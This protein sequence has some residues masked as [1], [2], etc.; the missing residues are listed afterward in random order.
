MVWQAV[1]GVSANT[2]L[3]LRLLGFLAPKV[4]CWLSSFWHSLSVPSQA[5]RVTRDSSTREDRTDRLSR[6]VSRHHRRLDFLQR[7]A[8]YLRVKCPDFVMTSAGQESKIDAILLKI[9]NLWTKTAGTAK[10]KNLVLIL[11]D[12]FELLHTKKKTMSKSAAGPDA[13]SCTP[14]PAPLSVTKHRNNPAKRRLKFRNTSL[15]SVRPSY[16][17]TPETADS[18][19]PLGPPAI[20]HTPENTTAVRTS[21]PTTWNIILAGLPSAIRH[22]ER[23]IGRRSL[24]FKNV[25][26]KLGS[27]SNYIMIKSSYRKGV[28]LKPILILSSYN[29]GDLL[30]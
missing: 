22:Y 28:S 6:N 9:F 18:P 26:K 11:Q 21:N 24:R 13:L 16:T 19:K 27:I 12:L 30:G 14:M 15:S 17:P 1:P 5:G 29:V 3:D 10:K 2:S 20:L 8:L 25:I 4:G 7:N 23:V